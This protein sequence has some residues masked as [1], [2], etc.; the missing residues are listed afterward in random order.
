[1]LL[2]EGA[3]SWQPFIHEFGLCYHFH[4]PSTSYATSIFEI[5]VVGCHLLFISHHKVG[6]PVPQTSLF[7]T[8]VCSSKYTGQTFSA[9]AVNM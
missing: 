4:Y 1:M 8:F 2:D 7:C 3:K 6:Q 9:V 5:V